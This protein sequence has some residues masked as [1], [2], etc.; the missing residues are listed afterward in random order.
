MK[1][2]FEWG[3]L[4]TILEARSYWCFPFIV[5]SGKLLWNKILAKISVSHGVKYILHSYIFKHAV[6]QEV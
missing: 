3:F 4:S 2:K 1:T 6:T 5:F